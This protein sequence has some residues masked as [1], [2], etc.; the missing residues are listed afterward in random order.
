MLVEG[1]S[2]QHYLAGIKSLLVSE[3]LIKPKRELVFPPCGGTKTARA[4]AGIL[5]GRD[6]V[7]PKV[8]L[9][10]DIPGRRLAESLKTE[11]YAAAPDRVLMVTDFVDYDKAE[12]ED[13]FPPE[14]LAEELDRMERAP[15]VRL[16]DVIKSGEPFVGQVE[17]WARD[18][19]FNLDPHWKVHLSVKVKQRALSRGIE[20]FPVEIV[21]RWVRLFKA[22]V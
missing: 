19:G 18:Q 15:E 22:F 20:D 5:T 8:L 7:L 17:A 2:D 3:G 11:L 13:L 10:G 14:Y 1:A 21:E 6:D 4:V 9:D 16:S 12:I